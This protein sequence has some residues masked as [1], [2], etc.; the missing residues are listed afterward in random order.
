MRVAIVGAGIAG[1]SC[2]DALRAAG[3]QPT[4]FDKSRG[5]GGRMSTRRAQ[6]P[7]G[8]IAFDHGATH[9]TARSLEF[10]SIVDQWHAQGLAAPWPVA[11]ADAWVGTPAM[12]T[13]VRALANRHDILWS[14]PVTALTRDGRGWWVHIEAN[15]HGPYD[16]MVIAIPAEQAAPLLSL[17]DFDMARAAMSVRSH[18]SWSA[19]YL[20]ERRVDALPD[21]IRGAGPIS[22]AVRNSA[23]PARGPGETWVVQANWA[24]SEAHLTLDKARIC[25]L[26]LG[27]LGEAAGTEMPE[28]LHADAHRWLFS[29]PSGR[30]PELLWNSDINLGA[31]GDWLA[32]GFV[33][34]AW[35][36]GT[37]LG[38][39]IAG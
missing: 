6:T 26:L 3:H 1:L 17:H 10:R 23:K 33:E 4:L 13:P 35:Q 19:M 27:A 25:D 16:A 18:P 9:F 7:R 24:W 8:E 39:A 2:A 14:S 20:F 36:N 21:F 22:C 11:G 12:N 5:A 38:R 34:Y 32:H 28:A 29:Q 30:E 31:C 37:A 15:R